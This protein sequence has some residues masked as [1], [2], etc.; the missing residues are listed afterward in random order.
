MSIRTESVAI[1]AAL[2]PVRALGVHWGTFQLTFEG[3]DDPPRAPRRR[4]ARA[5]HRPGPLRRDRGRG[6]VQR[7]GTMSFSALGRMR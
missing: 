6:D 2:N 7:A 5:G 1:F 3:I 4:A